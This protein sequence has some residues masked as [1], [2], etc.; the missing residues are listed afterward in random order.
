[1]SSATC[2]VCDAAIQAAD[3]VMEGE[4][5]TC[6]DCGMELEVASLS[7]LTLVEAPEVQEDWG[8]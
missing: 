3:D 2:P 6:T 5:L 8:E 4:L 1:M 7:P